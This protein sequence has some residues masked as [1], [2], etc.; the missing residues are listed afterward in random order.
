MKNRK[1]KK[2]IKNNKAIFFMILIILIIIL[3]FFIY[4]KMFKNNKVG[5]NMNSEQIVDYILNVNSYKA[6]I[7]VETISNKNNNKYILIQEYNTENGNIEEVIEPSNISGLKIIKKNN[8]LRI[9]NSNLNLNKIFEN[10]S[11]LENNHLDLSSF[12]NDYKNS[13]NSSYKEENNEII[14]ETKSNNK[15]L[16]NKALYIDK[17]L[18]KPIKLIISDNNQK[19]IINIIYNEIELN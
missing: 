13:S 17:N 19:S 5:D 3:I 11:E 2:S 18:I 6:K 7:Y 16:K 15:Y 1:I 12:I 9:E 8:T 10:Y 14:M 4:K